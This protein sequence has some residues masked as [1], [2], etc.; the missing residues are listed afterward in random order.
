MSLLD[1]A[2]TQEEDGTWTVLCPVTDGSC[3]TKKEDGTLDTPFVSTGWPTKKVARARLAEHVDDHR[4][5]APAS[6]LEEFR[7]KHGLQG[8]A[9]G[10]RAV[11]TVEDL[12]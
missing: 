6:T 4:G 11:V 7:A 3:G 12:S 8:T 2:V 10:K 9:D 5:V 1:K